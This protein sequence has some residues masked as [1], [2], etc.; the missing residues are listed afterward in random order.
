MASRCCD[1]FPES[2]HVVEIGLV[3]LSDLRIWEFAKKNDF[4][5]VTKDRDFREF[6]L[7]M[8]APPKLISISMSNCSTRHIE[9]A[10]RDN[11]IRIA[12]FAR[13]EQTSLLVIRRLV[14]AG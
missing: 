14:D 8:G 4:I 13:S 1:P 7:D 6:S 5:I 3:S 10:L 11:S 12:D 2:M 9:R